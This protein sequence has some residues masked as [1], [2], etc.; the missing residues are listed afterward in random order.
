MRD[1]CML[2]AH[3]EYLVFAP[4]W[5]STDPPRVVSSA[6]CE[7]LL[8]LTGASRDLHTCRWHLCDDTVL[9]SLS[10]DSKAILNF[11]VTSG[12]GVISTQAAPDASG[13]E[14]EA[15]HANGHVVFARGSHLE[16]VRHSIASGCVHQMRPV[17]MGDNHRSGT[18]HHISSNIMV[19]I[20]SSSHYSCSPNGRYIAAGIRRK[21]FAGARIIDTATGESCFSMSK[22]AHFS[23]CR[24][25]TCQWWEPAVEPM[26][27][28]SWSPNGR[29]VC[30]AL[31]ITDMVHYNAYICQHGQEKGKAAAVFIVDTDTWKP[32]PLAVPVI[33]HAACDR[34]PVSWL[35]DSCGMIVPKAPS[36]SD[37]MMF[38]L[39]DNPVQQC[40]SLISFGD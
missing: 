15:F 40:F 11:S 24:R 1:Y 31:T 25:R 21:N 19:K 26:F 17:C 29:Y 7:P 13:L 35:P 16:T 20:G 39:P 2:S 6:G 33:Y 38:R 34:A 8:M 10:A 22:E 28:P 32:C 36:S 3:G 9:A 5:P 37:S 12:G 23:R 30:F 27:S 4:A 14:L 18:M